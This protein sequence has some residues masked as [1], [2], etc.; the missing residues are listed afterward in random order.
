M[1]L[2]G[3]DVNKVEKT[4]EYVVSCPDASILI[5]LSS[6]LHSYL[7]QDPSACPIGS[8][9]QAVIRSVWQV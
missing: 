1:V 9:S 5:F 2:K 8:F 4:G 6:T 7:P 3:G